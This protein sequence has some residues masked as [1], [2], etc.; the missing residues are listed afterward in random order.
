MSKIQK[1]S[2]L[3]GQI[4][5]SEFDFYKRYQQSFYASELGQLFCAIPF[6]SLADSL[7]LKDSRKGHNPYF[8]AEGKLTLNLS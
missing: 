2:D 4:P 6:S 1:L 8:S 5:F 7:G 3:E